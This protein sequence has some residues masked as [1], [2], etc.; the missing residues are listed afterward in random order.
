[1]TVIT[2]K[3]YV[4][5]LAAYNNGKLHGMWIDATDDLNSI[6]DQVNSMLEHSPEPDA[7]EYAIHDFEGFETY[8]LSEYSGLKEAHK[9]A[10]FIAEHGMLASELLDYF[11]DNLE[12]AQ[13]TLE[14]NYAGEYSS[15]A[16]FAQ[17]LTEET[18]DV[19]QNIAYYIDYEAMAR[20]LE[21][22]DLLTIETGHQK[23]HIFWKH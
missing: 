3:I 7:E 22:N 1:M 6:Q 4:A 8:R 20:D 16:D 2:P 18:T 17:E 15:V 9:I 10:C 19:P 12:Y 21:I 23:V 13:N 5:C 14:N 11:G